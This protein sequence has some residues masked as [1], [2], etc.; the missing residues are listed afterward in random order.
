MRAWASPSRLGWRI[1]SSF[2]AIGQPVF[3]GLLPGLRELRAPIAAGV[4]WLTFG[5]MIGQRLIHLPPADQIRHREGAYG[6]LLRLWEATPIAGRVAVVAFFA[7]LVGSLALDLQPALWRRLVRLKRDRHIPERVD[8]LL[9]RAS[10][11]VS[12]RGRR[13]VQ[14]AVDRKLRTLEGRWPTET[15]Q[16]ATRLIIGK[17]PG[18][19]GW[20]TAIEVRADQILDELDLVRTRLI[21]EH[22]ELVAD[23][24]RYHSE[25]DMRRAIV[26]PGLLIVLALAFDESG[27]WLLVLPL[28]GLVA[29]QAAD[30]RLRAGDLLADAILVGKV[31]PAALAELPHEIEL[32]TRKLE[33]EDIPSLR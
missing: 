28:I 10:E 24:D 16:Q 6:A 32:A 15:L 8:S 31:E 25:A 22:S 9:R 20:G 29:R 17:A 27:L 1:P 18:E 33:G 14:L 3:S 21:D 30:R 2:A 19:M 7:Y 5:W 12:Y 13:A 23:Y 4:L 11:P 26:V